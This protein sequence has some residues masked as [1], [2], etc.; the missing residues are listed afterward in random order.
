MEQ[1]RLLRTA[2]RSPLEGELYGQEV[3]EPAPGWGWA[4]ERSVAAPW[5]YL[6]TVH[7][8]TSP[9]FA[10]VLFLL[11]RRPLSPRSPAPHQATGPPFPPCVRLRAVIA[12][13]SC[14]SFLS[15][16]YRTPVS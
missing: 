5:T 15:L 8:P 14:P 7:G 3:G 13:F 12:C 4:D 9:R 11:Q 16:I 6:P 1:H 2:S 10:L